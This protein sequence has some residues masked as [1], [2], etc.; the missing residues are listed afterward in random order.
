MC[1]LPILRSPDLSKPFVVQTD[2]SE[3]GIGA[4]LSQEGPDDEHPVAYISR[5]LRPRESKYAT[6]EKEF[7]AIVWTVQTLQVYLRGQYFTIQTDHHPL[8]WLQLV[9]DKNSCLTR[10]SLSLQP[11]KFKIN[12][13]RGKE[14]TNTDTLSKLPA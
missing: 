10:W 9:K 5:K 6:I 13:C 3:R 2:A 11:Y 8:Q 4:V 14:N 12:H 7:L 1:S